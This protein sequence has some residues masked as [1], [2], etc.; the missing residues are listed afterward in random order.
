[1]PERKASSGTILDFGLKKQN[2]FKALKIQ[3][4]NLETIFRGF[5]SDNNYIINRQRH[6]SVIIFL[7]NNKFFAF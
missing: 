6:W 7:D 4:Q 2:N 5:R 1:V 3:G